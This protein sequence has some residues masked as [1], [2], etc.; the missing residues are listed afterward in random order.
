MKK[1]IQ[2]RELMKFSP[3]ELSDGLKSDLNVIMEDGEVHFVTHR[4][5]IVLRYLLQLFEMF[6]QLRIES[7][8]LLRNYFSSNGLFTSKSIPKWFEVTIKDIVEY[9]VKPQNN[10]KILADVYR[11]IWE[12]NNQIYNEI[13]YKNLGYSSS[14]NI[15]EFLEIQVDKRLINSMRNVAIKQT[16]ESVRN[17]YKVLEDIIYNKKELK[18]NQIVKNYIAGTINQNQVKQIL[19]SRGFLTEINNMIYKYPIASSFCLGLS[20]IY[21][22]SVESRAAAKALSVAISSIQDSEYFARETQLVTMITEKLVDGDCGN[23]DYVEWYVKGSKDGEKSDIPNLV[24]KRWYNPKTKKEEVIGPKDTHLEGQTIKLRSAINCKLPDARCVCTACFG[25]LA[26]AIPLHSN[27]GHYCT[28]E[29]TEQITQGLLS[30]KHHTGSA[31]SGAIV[32]DKVGEQFFTLSDNT[33]Y[34]RSNLFKSGKMKYYLIVDQKSGF[35]LKDLNPTVN[36]NKLNTARVSRILEIFIQE[37]G[38]GVDM[39]YPIRIEVNKRYGSFTYQFLDYVAKNGFIMDDNDR[40][41]IDLSKWDPKDSVISMPEVEYDFKTLLTALKHEIKNMKTDEIGVGYETP[42]SLVQ[43]LFDLLNGR[44][45]VNVA[46]IEIIVYSFTVKDPDIGDYSLARGI[47]DKKLGKIKSVV[48]NR[49]L[50]AG[51]GWEQ[52]IRLILSPRSYQGHNSVE[53]P[54]DIFIK[55]NEVIKKH[56]GRLG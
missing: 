7:K 50:G 28:T 52:L 55:P 3:K 1:A 54:M 45:S 49:S 32:L 4:E 47:K 44:I 37:V 22:M 24:G 51:Y 31:S 48:K 42:E 11:E 33:Y 39:I 21:D 53:H 19:A 13:V 56:Y 30:T 25:D 17:S 38:P 43:K 27:I 29:I 8:H 35:G 15:E 46:L 36:V 34:L 41:V 26:Y 20:N 14:V 12:I 18:N 6:P 2:I 40:Y 16:P 9:I 5:L 23:T 10:R